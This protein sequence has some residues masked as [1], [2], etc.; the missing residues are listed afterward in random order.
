MK[1]LLSI[2]DESTTS[3]SVASV[4]GAVGNSPL[5]RP[6]DTIFAAENE[7]CEATPAATSSSPSNF[8]LWKNSA[9]VGKEQQGKHGRKK[10]KVDKT[11]MYP[12]LKESKKQ[13]DSDDY[14]DPTE[15]DYDDDYQDM[16]KRVGAKAKKQETEKKSK[17]DKLN[18]V[19][20]RNFDS[21]EDYH[22]AVRNQGKQQFSGDWDV[23]DEIASLEN[24]IKYTNSSALAHQLYQQIDKLKSDYGIED[25]EDEYEQ[26]YDADIRARKGVAEGKEFGSNYAEQLAQEVFN[27][28]ADIKDENQVLNLGY[29]I[30][31]SDLGRRAQ[32]IFNSE[33]FPSDFVSAYFYL[34]RQGAGRDQLDEKSVSKAQ[35]RTMAAAS[36]NPKFAKKVGISQDVAQEFHNA[37]KKSKY[38]SLPQKVDEAEITEEMIADRLK[39]ELA[40]FKKGSRAKDRE[41]GNKPQDREVQQKVT[42]I[43]DET[44][45]RYMK[46]VSVDSQKHKKDPTKRKPEKASRSVSGFAKASNR[47]DK[48]NK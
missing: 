31:K 27:H 12:Q 26:E 4:S 17:A 23:W 21:D 7:D 16:V 36:H 9:L 2:L 39:N 8:G 44:L 30:S 43:S 42:E 47:L 15:A 48:R 18:E 6:A 25:E 1:K 14:V 29:S 22:A 28:N 13:S 20:A 33:D 45:Q 34:Q 41:L 46:N 11:E 10:M 35:F 5:K 38:K 40:L 3:G 24:Q 32:A 19:D 37:D